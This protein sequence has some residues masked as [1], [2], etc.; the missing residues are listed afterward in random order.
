MELKEQKSLTKLQCFG[1]IPKLLLLLCYISPPLKRFTGSG[2]K[3]LAGET[4]RAL[5]I[6]K[7]WWF[8]ANAFPHIGESRLCSMP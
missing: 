4:A 1:F 8:I 3:D 2:E 7:I 5:G 6:I